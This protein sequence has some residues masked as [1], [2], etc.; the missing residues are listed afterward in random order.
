MIVKCGKDIYLRELNDND[1][2]DILEIVYDCAA[3]STLI[4][5]DKYKREKS[6]R[7]SMYDIFEKDFYAKLQ[8]NFNHFDDIMTRKKIT[9]GSTQYDMR[10][11]PKV[12]QPVVRKFS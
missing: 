1:Y 12:K 3:L 8:K 10:K 2:D 7:H 4:L 6:F 5:Y 11:F 9:I